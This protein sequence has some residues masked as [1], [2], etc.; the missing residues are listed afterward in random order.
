MV[1]LVGTKKIINSF[2]KYLLSGSYC[3]IE[4]GVCAGFVSPEEGP[5][6]DIYGRDTDEEDNPE[7]TYALS[8]C[9]FC[10]SGP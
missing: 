2:S 8:S 6:G 7:C 9:V 5:N 4:H 10:M 1:I 3:S